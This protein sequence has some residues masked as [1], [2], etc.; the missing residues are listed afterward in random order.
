MAATRSEILLDR[1]GTGLM[2]VFGGY[3][4]LA[5]ATGNERLAVTALLLA[6]LVPATFL[7]LAAKAQGRS[8]IGFGLLALLGPLGGFYA[9]WRLNRSA[10]HLRALAFAAIESQMPARYV[11]ADGVVHEDKGEIG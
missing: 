9:W 10:S 5:M 1:A 7:A 6:N 4:A 8:V 3:M 2:L 11:D